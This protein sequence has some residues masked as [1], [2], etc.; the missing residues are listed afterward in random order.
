VNDQRN[1]G[2]NEQQVNEKSGDV[3]K[4]KSAS[5]KNHEKYR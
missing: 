5:P 2:K 1:H 3:E 4:H